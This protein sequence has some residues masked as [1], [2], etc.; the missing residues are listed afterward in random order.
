[1]AT[2]EE[3]EFAMLRKVAGVMGACAAELPIDSK[4]GKEVAEGGRRLLRLGRDE[5]DGAPHLTLVG[6]D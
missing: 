2:E 6:R 5:L 4:V 3:L 1:M